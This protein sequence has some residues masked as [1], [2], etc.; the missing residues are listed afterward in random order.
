M[1]KA[2]NGCLCILFPFWGQAQLLEKANPFL[3]EMVTGNRN[4]YVLPLDKSSVIGSYPLGINEQKTVHVLFPS[5]IK[6]VDVGSQFV[7]VQVTEAF[8]N[9]LRIKANSNTTFKETNITVICKD[10]S[11]YSFLANYRENPEVINLSIG[12]NRTSDERIS[13]ELG[14]NFTPHRVLNENDESFT[15]IQDLAQRAL[16]KSGFIHNVGVYAMKVTALLTG[17]FTKGNNLY[18]RVEVRNRSEI[19]YRIDFAKVFISDVSELRRV[20][21]Q[22]EEIPVKYRLPTDNS[23][24][25]AS[26]KTFVF[27][28]PIRALSASK[29]VDFELFEEKGARH[30]RFTIDSKLIQKAKQL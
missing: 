27:V 7:V 12:H 21:V 22:E 18:Y 4:H 5:E 11:L 23:I 10:G 29:Q 15:E 3:F 26:E 20:A 9:V 1:K 6:E 13:K 30:L 17:I 2:I 25:A 28:V 16:D 14:I 24:P 19:E 8:N